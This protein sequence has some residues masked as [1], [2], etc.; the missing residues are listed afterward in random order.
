AE[1][2]RGRVGADP[3]DLVGRDPGVLEGDGPRPTGFASVGPRLDHVVGVRCGAVAHE[4]GIRLGTA[5]ASDLLGLE[6]EQGRALAH[7]EPV[8]L[9]VEWPAG[10]SRVVVMAIRQGPDDVE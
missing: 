10:V 2:R 4:L 8:A 9:G 6:Y 5:G 1:R 7:D 3:V